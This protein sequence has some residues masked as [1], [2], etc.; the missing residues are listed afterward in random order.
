[1]ESSITY[2]GADISSFLLRLIGHKS[3]TGVKYTLKHSCHNY[4]CVSFLLVVGYVDCS[5]IIYTEQSLGG[6]MHKGD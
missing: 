4:S 2:L 5:C 6:S 3:V 1:M